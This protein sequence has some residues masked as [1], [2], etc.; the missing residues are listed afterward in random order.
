MD[1]PGLDPAAHRR[2][3]RGLGRLN[4]LSFA[5]ALLWPA[6]ADLLEPD[7][8]LRILDLACG[9]GDVPIA[10]W[11]R[12]RRAHRPVHIDASDVSP[13][14]LDYARTRAQRAGADVSFFLLSALSDAI[15]GDYDVVVC[16]LFLHHLRE[17]QAAGLLRRAGA[18]ARR[19]LVISD[20]A[21]SPLNIAL[22]SA[23]AHGVT[24]SPIVHTDAARSAKAAFSIAE[25]RELAARAGLIGARVEPRFPCRFLLTWDKP[26]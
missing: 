17:D 1:E 2:A 13:T 18:A 11:R 15:P 9:G 21:R 8:P 14:A 19:R 7:R 3:L 5:P 20:L 24:M 4:A 10:L 25:A 6:I 26:R 16:S 12:A 23:A 22:I